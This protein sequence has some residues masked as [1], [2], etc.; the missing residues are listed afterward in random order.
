M[1]SGIAPARADAN[2]LTLEYAD[3]GRTLAERPK[4]PQNRTPHRAALAFGNEI[5]SQYHCPQK[6]TLG[7]I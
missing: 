3:I 4:C 7:R 1:G 2:I 6:W 5:E